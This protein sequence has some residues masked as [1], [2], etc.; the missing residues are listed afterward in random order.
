LCKGLLEMKGERPTGDVEISVQWASSS[1]LPIPHVPDLVRIPHDYFRHIETAHRLLRPER[2]T[3][4]VARLV[5]TVETLNGDVGT[6]GRRAGEVV[7]A[8]LPPNDAEELVRAR[9]ELDADD[10]AKAAEAHTRGTVYVRLKGR[11]KRGAR[12][13]RI[14]D[15]RDFELDEG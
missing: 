6:D 8:I 7:L 11:L 13:S 5:G 9:V 15:V 1:E 3:D 4:D 14:E 12:I 2:E 10:Y